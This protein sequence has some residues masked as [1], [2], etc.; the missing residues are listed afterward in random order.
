[1]GGGKFAGVVKDLIEMERQPI[2]NLEVRKAREQAKGK[3]FGEFKNAINA[4][5][6]SIDGVSNF[7][8]LIEYKVDLGEGEKLMD[9]TVDKDKVKP[10]SWD[11]EIEELAHHAAVISNGVKDPNEKVLG[12]GA[13]SVKK[14]NGDVFDI[15][16]D[17]KE[18]SLKGI[19]SAINNTPDTPITATVIEDVYTPDRPWRLIIN[20][21]KAGEPDGVEFAD[22][23]F[24]GGREKFYVDKDRDGKNAFL[25][26]NGF[27]IDSRGNEVGNFLEGINVK[28]KGAAP[29]KPFTLKITPDYPKVVSKVEALTNDLNK[30]LKFINDQNKVDDKTDTKTMFTGDTGL[31][32][33]EYRLRNLM[34]EGFY[35]E[36]REKG[37]YRLM[38]LNQLGIEFNKDGSVKLNKDKFQNMLEKD[39]EGVSEA[40]SG[41][42]GFAPQLASILRGFTDPANGVVAVRDKAMQDRIRRI[43]DQIAQTEMRVE[44][45]AKSLTDK[46]S[47][48]EGTLSQMQAQ[49]NYMAATMGAGGNPIAQ[50]LGG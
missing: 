41:E 7:Q 4:L 29:D 46:F 21:K 2:K 33:I 10:G 42:G 27:Q 50:L 20:A 24:V 17:D 18:S 38:W 28:L 6:G 14:F 26:V 44:Q 13:I 16:I 19:A 35:V 23:Y 31:Q 22:F 37:G 40:I 49:Q 3:L 1:M 39:F 5:K 30:T 11:I 48:L 25:K 9:V 32:T 47:R 36:D 43:D 8:K 15:T 34:H 45:K 12:S